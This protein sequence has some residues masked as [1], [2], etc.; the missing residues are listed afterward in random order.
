MA[1]PRCFTPCRGWAVPP[2]GLTAGSGTVPGTFPLPKQLDGR[3]QGRSP[4][5]TA[6][7]WHEGES[8]A[9]ITWSSFRLILAWLSAAWS[10]FWLIPAWL[11][12]GFPSLAHRLEELARGSSLLNATKSPSD[13]A[14]N[15]A[16]EFPED[17]SASKAKHPKESP[18]HRICQLVAMTIRAEMEELPGGCVLCSFSLRDGGKKPLF[19]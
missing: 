14:D 1:M 4:A 9:T 19:C 8:S 17:P 10:S 18:R 5:G 11:N 16:A 12:A 15:P 2:V 7:V 13:S 6:A 3:E